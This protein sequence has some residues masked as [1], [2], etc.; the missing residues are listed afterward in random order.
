MRTIQIW[1]GLAFYLATCGSVTAAWKTVI[2]HRPGA[3]SSNVTDVREWKQVGYYSVSGST[4]V[5]AVMWSGTLDSLQEIEPVEADSSMAFGLD[6]NNQGGTL[7]FGTKQYAA[8]WNGSG[9]GWTNLD[10]GGGASRLFAM[11]ESQ[12]AG[13]AIVSTPAG[14]GTHAGYWRGSAESWVDLHP[15]TAVW[16]EVK[17]V[18]HADLQGGAI[19]FGELGSLNHAALWR[20]TAQS[21]VDLHPAGGRVSQVNAVTDTHQGGYYRPLATFSPLHAALWSGTAASMI[22]MH[23]GGND[24]SGIA[25]M[26]ANIQVGARSVLESGSVRLRATIWFGTQAS[27][28]DLH[29][30]LPSIYKISGTSSIWTDGISILIGGSASRLAPGGVAAGLEAVLWIW[31]GCRADFNRDAVVDD[32]DFVSFTASYEA[33]VVPPAD[34]QADLNHDGLVDDSDFVLFAAAYSQLTCD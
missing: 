27:W 30:Y 21:L 2:L 17:A 6:A 4:A 19:Y 10:P 15:S 3:K 16:S 23:P 26:Q 9:N 28:Q 32:T 8:L 24:D 18:S 5:H 34:P 13:Y 12:Q 7:S 31:D 14:G 25:A 29:Q 1:C 20:G 33:M 22:D 11:N